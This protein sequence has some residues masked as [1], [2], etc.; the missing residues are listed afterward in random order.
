[1]AY[2]VYVIKNLKNGI[3]IGQT[4]NLDD[5]IRRHNNNTEKYTKNKGPFELIYSEKFDTRAEAMKREKM[6]KSGKGREWIK[7]NLL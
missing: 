3:Y 5:R 2:S 7:S 6:L 4:N 1:M